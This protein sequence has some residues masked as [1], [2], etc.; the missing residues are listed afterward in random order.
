MNCRLWLVTLAAAF[1]LS[2][3]GDDK[4]SAAP[5]PEEPGCNFTKTDKVWKY[6]YPEWNITEIY[7]WIDDTTVQFEEYMNS[8]H[9]EDNDTTYT[10]INRDELFDQVMEDCQYFVYGQQQ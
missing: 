5:E 9:M 8:Y 4:S 7:T 2:A 3:C 1:C 6:T 10:D